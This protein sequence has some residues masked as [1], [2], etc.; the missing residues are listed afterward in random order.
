MWYRLFLF[1][2]IVSVGVVANPVSA[3]DSK[4][5]SE[6]VKFAGDVR[7]RHELIAEEKAASPD[8]TRIPDRNRHRL[9]L[10]FGLQAEVNEQL[11]VVA[12]LA[13]GIGDPVSTNQDLGEGFSGK[14][15]WLDRAY[16]DYHP[17]QRITARAGKA[18]VPFAGSD[19]LWDSD[20]NPEGIAMLPKLKFAHG[21]LFARGG[22]FWAAERKSADGPDQGLF[23][24]QVGAKI[25]NRKAHALLA[26]AYFDFGNVKDG[27][28]LYSSTKGFGN[29]V[30]MDGA[31][32]LYVSDFNLINFHSGA[33][34]Q[35]EHVEASLIGD[36][37]LNTGAEP[38]PGTSTT[39][40]TG[41]LAGIGFKFAAPLEWEVQYNYRSVDADAVIGA[42][43]D[44]DSAGGGTNFNG[45]KIAAAMTVLPGTKA[46]FAYMRNTRDPDGAKLAY[47]RLQVD[48][49]A[50]F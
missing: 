20:L 24:A 28:T 21:E 19:L 49:E 7:Y 39:R 42:L 33:G 44:S 6:R 10:R 4:S 18:G 22:G 31:Q 41:W 2:L 3:G 50:K 36:F 13:S 29:T 1:G 15:I 25:K 45:H 40:D 38:V 26:A 48:V 23:G 12:R 30:R 5:W 43:N 32:A 34:R 47:N 8:N 35:F 14:G 46:G 9:R 11:D 16:L 37:V 17:S 27:P